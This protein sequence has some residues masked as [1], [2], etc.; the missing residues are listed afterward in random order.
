MSIQ[1]AGIE[2]NNLNYTVH[3]P[4]NSTATTGG[5]SLAQNLNVFYEVCQGP[6]QQK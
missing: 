4:Y 1:G 6:Q 5:D 2:L 3:E